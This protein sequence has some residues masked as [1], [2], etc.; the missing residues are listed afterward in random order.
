MEVAAILAAILGD[1]LD[2]GLIV[3]LLVF[4]ATLGSFFFH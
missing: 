2:L 3:G 1:W 4:N